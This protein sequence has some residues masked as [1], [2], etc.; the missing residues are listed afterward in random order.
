[1]AVQSKFAV[2]KH[3]PSVGDCGCT[4][5]TDLPSI[6]TVT[7]APL[8][9]SMCPCAITSNAQLTFVPC[10]IGLCICEKKVGLPLIAVAIFPDAGGT[11]VGVALALGDGLT[12][13]AVFTADEL[14]FV[15]VDAFVDDLFELELAT[16]GLV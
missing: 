1:M 11:A 10:V 14:D 7:V 5:P 16:C 3:L 8:P 15:V 13:E 12:L 9:Q 2:A 4:C 6:K